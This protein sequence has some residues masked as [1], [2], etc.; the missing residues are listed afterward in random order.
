[1]QARQPLRLVREPLLPADAPTPSE[2]GISVAEAVYNVLN[3]YVG[4]GLL[5]KPYAVAEGGWCSVFA[6]AVLCATANVTGKLIVRGFAKLPDYLPKL[7]D[8]LPPELRLSPSPY[9]HPGAAD[10]HSEYADEGVARPTH[11]RG[12]QRGPRRAARDRRDR[13]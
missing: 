7:K 12:A 3:V 6:L 8:S 5:S 11:R 13:R 4:L 2:T 9:T 10:P 1:M